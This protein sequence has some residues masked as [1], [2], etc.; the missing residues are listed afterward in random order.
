MRARCSTPSKRRTERRCTDAATLVVQRYV[1]LARYHA[2][3]LDLAPDELAELL[4]GHRHGID[5]FGG[6]PLTQRGRPDGLV[7]LG[8][9]PRC[10]FAGQLRRAHDPVP[11]HAV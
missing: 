11:L 8:I 10:D 9:E 6:E 3:V 5:G 7:D 4:R 1:A 2:P